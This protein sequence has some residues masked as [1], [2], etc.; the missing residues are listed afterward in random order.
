M[1]SESLT[2]K[3]IR[4]SILTMA[5]TSV[6]AT[7]MFTSVANAEEE[8]A[9]V[10][11]IEVTGSRIKRTDMEGSSPITTIDAAAI[12]KTGEMSV[13][14]VLR[15]SNLNTFGSQSEASGS[16]WQSQ[17]NISLRGAGADRTLVLLNG[18][19]MPGS[20]TMGG[21]A[22]N[23]NTIPT[24]AIERIE[25]LTDGASAVYGSD[26]VAGVVNI[27]TKKDYDGFEVSATMTNPEQPGG[28]E[29]KTHVVGG[30][31]GD[32]GSM[33]FSLEHQN[34]EIIYQ[35]DRWFTSSSN[36]LADK[37]DDTT[38]VSAYAR[39]FL[40]MTTF[41]FSPMAACDNDKMVGGGHIYDYGG[42]D[43]I[44]GYDYTSEA[45]NHA[46]RAYTAGYVN[47]DYEISDE[48][49]FI[50]QGLFTRNETFGRYA[51]AAGWFNVEAG[52]IDIQNW[53]EDGNFLG[54]SKNANAGR[55]YYRFTDVGTRDSTTIDYS[56]DI[57][58]GLEG[59][60]DHFG[61]DVTY[62]Y[63]LAENSNY[64]SG[65]VHRPTVEALVKSG[66]FNFGPDGNDASVVAAITHD[67]LAQD[68]ME[69]QSINA[70][71]NFE[72]FEL[73]AGLVGFYFGSE[74]SDYKYHSRVDSESANGEVIGSSG[75]GSAGDRD[76][77]A[78]FGESI[79]PVTDDLEFNVALRYDKYSDFG[80]AVTP[81]VALR[82][83]VIDDV[84]VRASWGQGFRAPALSDL[85]AA[86]SF[87]ADLATDYHRCDIDG[88]APVDCTADQYDVTRTA[89]PDL[90]AETSD[91]YN[92]GVIWNITDDLSAKAEYYNL[93]VDNVISFISLDSL[94]REEAEVGYGNLARG[95]IIRAGDSPDGRI[96]EATTPLVNGNGFDTSGIDF[97]VT[98]G[99]YETS[100]GDFGT[101]FD[102]TWVLAYNSEEYFDGP[103]NDKIGRN[104]LPEYRF[105]WVID[106]S[107]GD[108]AASLLTQYI[109]GQAETVDPDTYAQIGSL[110]S[111]TTF[112]F[113]Y[114]YTAS[115]NGKF[116]LGVR[117]ITDQ[118][119]VLDSNLAYDD[120]LYNLYG[121]TFTATYTQ[122]F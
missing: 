71:I 120:A 29:W 14:D 77:F 118:D 11:R 36:I 122:K 20:P 5:A 97:N 40:D 46:S 48:I 61:W 16:N 62:H 86:D 100:F 73:P 119:P 68:I 109:D 93:K 32:K 53:D 98:Y 19:R 4:R 70:G 26:A 28:E 94:L 49:R 67:T 30:I 113:S 37:Y 21:T 106:W 69:F 72:A 65:Y 96:L 22:V 54:T 42:G 27:I 114:S 1:K 15:R 23:L 116:G 50:G 92:L 78:V 45:A 117:N 63:N 38:G 104:G 24:A 75:A 81:K 84:V 88:I 90:E 121:R 110:S 18:K 25:V 33:T 83:N 31:S 76:V 74:F 8:Q 34:R 57:Q 58:V 10:E 56:T 103:V 2:A 108:H 59:T 44:C 9:Q 41:Q 99:G 80:S 39:N 79:I 105:T 115:W 82:Y 51:P 7:G 102:L 85:Y 112:D 60:H 95:E 107:Y 13:A 55:T 6:A 91:F 66:D 43:Y 35:R 101:T 64:G 47:A 87:S 89:N 3:A 12:E 17:S 52:Q 111:Q